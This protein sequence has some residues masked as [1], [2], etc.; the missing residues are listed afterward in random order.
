MAI[1]KL[2]KK[3]DN[4]FNMEFPDSYVKIENIRID[5]ERELAKVDVRIYANE[6]ARTQ[7]KNGIKKDTVNIGFGQLTIT[8]LTKDEIKTQ[9]YEYI[10]NLTLYKDGVD[11]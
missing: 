8:E 5:V 2:I 7:N 11:V 6:E 3:I 4:D 9:C 1:K 10:K